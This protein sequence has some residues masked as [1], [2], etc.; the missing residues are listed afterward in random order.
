MELQ[1]NYQPISNVT[2]SKVS[3]GAFF[4]MLAI[5]A[6]AFDRP[7]ETFIRAHV[8]DI[9]PSHTVLLSREPAPSVYLGCQVL[10][11]LNTITPSKKPITR[12]KNGL[13]FRWRRY[14]DPALRGSDEIQVL[15]F[16]QKQRVR[17][18]L[19]EFGPTGNWLRVICNRANIPLYV[20]FHGYDVTTRPKQA[21]FRRF[22]RR[23]F[24]DIAGAIVPSKFLSERLI[25]LGCSKEKIHICPNGVE[26]SAFSESKRK[27]GTIL[28]VGRL[29][30]KKAPHLTIRA[31]AKAHR[32]HPDSVLHIIGDGPLWDRCIKEIDRLVLN[33]RVHLHGAQNPDFVRQKLR[34]AEIFVQHSITAKD[35]DME[36]FGVSLIEAMASFVPVVATNHNGFSDTVSNGNTG[37]LVDE[38]DIDS[39]ADA[40]SALLSDPIR[41]AKMGRSGRRRVETEFTNQRV[42]AR[43]REIMG[44]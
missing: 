28:A 2:A 14:V 20:F 25:S 35:G 13:R 41:A 33:G 26:L 10:S 5:A 44:I 32:Y 36:S 17:V 21:P 39:M 11:G 34:E 1:R 31:F 30:E 18:V 12:L 29:V 15:S 19:A 4:K 37:I 27:K 16:L 6:D 23:L 7:S 22:Y 40:I 9:A 8:K 43:M 24:R 3:A 42:A 38:H